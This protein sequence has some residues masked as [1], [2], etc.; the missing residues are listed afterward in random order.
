M[1]KQPTTTMAPVDSFTMPLNNPACR[2]I[3]TA[4]DSTVLLTTS[5]AY[6]ETMRHI[7]IEMTPNAWTFTATDAY[8]LAQV[9]MPTPTA[10]GHPQP[11]GS[12]LIHRDTAKAWA[13][14]LR[15]RTTTYALLTVGSEDLALAI[16]S[17]TVQTV[18]RAHHDFP[19]YRTFFLDDVHAWP[20]TTRY[21]PELWALDPNRL[22]NLCKSAAAIAPKTD[23]RLDNV[24]HHPNKPSYWHA[25]ADHITWTGLLMPVRIR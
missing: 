10:D 20:M 12:W 22:A 14:A 16:N 13:K 17:D 21:E 23:M 15:A 25:N 24:A 9:T 7:L 19:N 1:A 18:R 4:L 5:D 3:A 8:G 11:K 2:D 6:R